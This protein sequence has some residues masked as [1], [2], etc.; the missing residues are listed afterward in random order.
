[1][2]CTNGA[3]DTECQGFLTFPSFV[4]REYL[5]MISLALNLDCGCCD[6]DDARQSQ[7]GPS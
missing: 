7:V 2:A 5:F 4:I 6:H 3:T 1:M